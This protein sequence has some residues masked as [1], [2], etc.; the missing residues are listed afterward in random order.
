MTIQKSLFDFQRE[1]GMAGWL[2]ILYWQDHSLDTESEWRPV[3]NGSAV[4]DSDA[5]KVLKISV[6]TATRLRR[7]LCDAGLIRTK[8]CRRG[9]FRIWLLNL[10]RR[11]ELALGN[12]EV[13]PQMQTELVQ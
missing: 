2:F 13:W 7:R 8:A 5:A 11:Q 1:V 4:R 9:G 12:H 10:N 3:S 6:S